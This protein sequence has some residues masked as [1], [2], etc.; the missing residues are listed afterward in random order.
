MLFYLFAVLCVADPATS[1]SGNVALGTLFFS[2]D[3]LFIQLWEKYIFLSLYYH[4][5]HIDGV[6]ILSLNFYT[7]PL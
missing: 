5:V 7:V 4:L 6:K 1:L 2:E 3:G